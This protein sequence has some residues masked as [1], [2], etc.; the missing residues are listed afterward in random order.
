MPVKGRNF[1]I[2]QRFVWI[3]EQKDTPHVDYMTQTLDAKL[4][5]ILLQLR[6]S[7]GVT[8]S[9]ATLQQGGDGVSQENVPQVNTNNPYVVP[10]IMKKSDSP[11]I[12]MAVRSSNDCDRISV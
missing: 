2:N 7:T 12:L 4:Q 3:M 9:G 1:E 10:P 8:S 5:S 11:K 6:A